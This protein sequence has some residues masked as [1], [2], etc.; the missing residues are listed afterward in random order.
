MDC[1]VRHYGYDNVKGILIL[2]VVFGHFLELCPSTPLKNTL[3][4]VIY[5]FHMP[6]FLFF[7]GFFAKFDSGRIRQLAV[8]YGIFQ[9]L[10]RV[11][12]YFSLHTTGALEPGA[13]LF[14]PYWLLWYIPVLICCQLLLPL[15]TRRN[16]RQKQFLLIGSVCIALL[17]GYCSQIGY[18]LTLSRF[19]VFLPFYLAGNLAG[20]H[21]RRISTPAPRLCRIFPVL[22][23]L[24][25]VS[26]VFLCK[27]GLFSAKMLYGSYSYAIGYHPGIRLL[28]MGIAAGWIALFSILADSILNRV[29]PVLTYIGKNTLP[30]YL[31]HG[32]IVKYIGTYFPPIPLHAAFICSA[33]AITILGNPAAVQLFK[34]ILPASK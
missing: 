34:Q 6:A 5:S 12:A 31:F 2:C 20:T 3:Y 21:R 25:F 7:S 17:C 27:S 32:F 14:V 1:G 11:F 4:L 30:I 28:A 8:L 26:I 19:L 24:V 29:I 33:A 10:Y 16:A 13:V 22:A 23:T 15:W 18:G 9:V